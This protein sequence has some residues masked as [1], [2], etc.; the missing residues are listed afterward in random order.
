MKQTNFHFWSQTEN[1]KKSCRGCKLLQ[2]VLALL[3]KSKSP[4]LLVKFCQNREISNSHR[5]KKGGSKGV[6][7]A[8]MLVLYVLVDQ[9]ASILIYYKKSKENFFQINFSCW[10]FRSM[11]NLVWPIVSGN[12][13]PIISKPKR[14]YTVKKILNKTDF[15]PISGGSKG[16]WARYY[17]W[18]VRGTKRKAYNEM[19]QLF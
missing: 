8:N 11:A 18:K 5:S 7:V 14:P 1:G 13:E 19:T 2:I 16:V 3:K 6:R 17:K 9:K 10:Y 15:F 4:H 12:V